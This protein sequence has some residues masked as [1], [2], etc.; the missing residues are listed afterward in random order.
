[1]PEPKVDI[2][3]TRR[4]RAGRALIGRKRMLQKAKPVRCCASASTLALRQGKAM[5]RHAFA[6][7]EGIVSK[8]LTSRYKSGACRSWFKVDAPL[9][10]RR[11][12]A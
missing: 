1:M 8:K 2:R 10:V 6:G 11:A 3:L 9:Y 7:L 5:F 12:G 4:M